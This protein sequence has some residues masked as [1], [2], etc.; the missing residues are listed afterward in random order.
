MLTYM[1]HV[2]YLLAAYEIMKFIKFIF[3]VIY[4]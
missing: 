3:I 1:L 4:L 2:Y